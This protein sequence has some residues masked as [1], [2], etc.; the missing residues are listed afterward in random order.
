MLTLTNP[1]LQSAPLTY[2]R[3]FVER[4]G[5]VYF[6]YQSKP[7]VLNTARLN[8]VAA[9]AMLTQLG[10]PSD[11]PTLPVELTAASYQGTWDFRDAMSAVS[12]TEGTTIFINGSGAVSCLDKSTATFFGCTLTI[13]DAVTGAFNYSEAGTGTVASGTF[14]YMTGTATGMY[15]DPTSTPTDGS[16]VG[17]RR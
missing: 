9:G 7:V 11:D 5:Y 17:A 14:G 1:P 12:A 8:V 10:I 4:G 13:T 16:I 6:G 2:N 15:H 3:V